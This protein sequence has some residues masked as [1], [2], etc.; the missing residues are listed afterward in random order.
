MIQ[1]VFSPKAIY[2]VLVTLVVIGFVTNFDYQYRAG[3]LIYE[4]PFL[5]KMKFFYSLISIGLLALG[6]YV[7]VR[8]QTN[9]FLIF[10]LLFWI[11][12]GLVYNGAFDDVATSCF[13]LICIILR[14][15]LIVKLYKARK[16]E[17][18]VD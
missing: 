17:L 18:Q 8:W 5:S 11:F 14:I 9:S 16:K 3:C 4:V 6:Y 2:R 12:R 15:V 7:S 10:E 1:Q 13:F